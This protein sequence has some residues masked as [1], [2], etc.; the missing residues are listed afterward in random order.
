MNSLLTCTNNQGFSI[1][2]ITLWC[3]TSTFLF[4][5]KHN[6]TIVDKYMVLIEISFVDEILILIILTGIRKFQQ[7]EFHIFTL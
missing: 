7:P 2:A 6:S 1:I 4:M 5:K 3:S